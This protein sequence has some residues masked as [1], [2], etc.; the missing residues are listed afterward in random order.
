MRP[1]EHGRAST[2]SMFMSRGLANFL[3]LQ[4]NIGDELEQPNA[5]PAYT[6]SYDV[7]DTWQF[8]CD[9]T[10]GSE[11]RLADRDKDKIYIFN[12]ETFH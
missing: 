2:F 1:G 3:R 7:P 8:V 9:S 5:I 12:D 6:E 10:V 11:T 4:V